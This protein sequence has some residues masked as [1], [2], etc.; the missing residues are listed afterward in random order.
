MRL[1]DEAKAR[2]GASFDLAAWHD[3]ALKLGN[4]GLDLLEQELGRI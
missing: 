1:R 4:L 3:R 2:H